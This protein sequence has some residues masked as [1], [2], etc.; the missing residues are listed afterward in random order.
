MIEELLSAL[1]Y[2]MPDESMLTAADNGPTWDA[3]IDLCQR[4]RAMLKERADAAMED[5]TT[6]CAHQ[7]E[8]EYNGDV[9]AWRCLICLEEEPYSVPAQ[10]SDK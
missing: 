4:A 8:K 2:W 1:H 3:H 9:A 6:A 7:W 5:A 10:G